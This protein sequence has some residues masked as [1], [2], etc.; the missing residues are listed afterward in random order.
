MVE[1]QAEAATLNPETTTTGQNQIAQNRADLPIQGRAFTDLNVVKAKDPVPPQAAPIGSAA[2]SAGSNV[3]MQT[4]SSVTVQASPRWTVSPAGT[5]QRSSD[6]G[7]TWQTVDPS[8]SLSVSMAR[9]A[10]TAQAGPVATDPKKENLNR[11]TGTA[12]NPSPVFRAVAANGPEVWAGASGGLLYHSPDGGN[13]WLL[14]APAEVGTILTGDIVNIQFSDPQYGRIA[15]SS[16]ELW[17]TFDAGQT[18]HKQQ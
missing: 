3:A 4:S 10:V 18:W 12:P 6:G 7:S 1:V 17:T 11:K 14:V 13:R 16:A 15:T 2:T 8:A 9:A 5:L